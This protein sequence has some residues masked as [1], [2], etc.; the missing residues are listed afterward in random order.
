MSDF[1]FVAQEMLDNWMMSGKIDFSGHVMTIKGDKR[2]YVLESALRFV[3]VLGEEADEAGLIGKVKTL[4][5]VVEAGGEHYEDSVILNDVAYEVQMGFVARVTLPPDTIPPAKG[6]AAGVRE[7]I[8]SPAK[9]APSDAVP[10]QAAPAPGLAPSAAPAK[11]VE[12]HKFEPPKE[13]KAVQ[14]TPQAPA[15]PDSPAT[16]TKEDAQLLADFLLKNLS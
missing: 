4:D 11:K 9:P 16:S 5:Q 8:P 13:T 2:S 10:V 15:P 7:A 12:T 1:L 6:L 3:R 14:A